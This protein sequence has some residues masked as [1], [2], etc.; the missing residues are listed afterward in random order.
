MPPNQQGFVNQ[1]LK[2]TNGEGGGMEQY[3]GFTKQ[4]FR[5]VRQL[6]D[7]EWRVYCCLREKADF[8][9]GRLEH[10]TALKMTAASIAR[11]ISLP[12]QSGVP[13]LD[14]SRFDVLRSLDRLE[15][16]GFI[17]EREREGR[18]LRLRMP[19]VLTNTAK[20]E[21]SQTRV[22]PKNA[23]GATNSS[24]GVQQTKIA[25]TQAGQGFQEFSAARVQ[26]E[27]ASG[28]NEKSAR[29]QQTENA[30]I[31]ETVAAQGIADGKIVPFSTVFSTKNLQYSP[32]PPKN[33]GEENPLPSASE[34]PNPN[35]PS[36]DG[37]QEEAEKTETEIRRL[38]TVV[39]NSA[40]ECGGVIRCLNSAKS[41]EVLESWIPAGFKDWWI[42]DAVKLVIETPSEQPFVNAIDAVM[43]KWSAN[44]QKKSL[45][46]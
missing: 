15:Y 25:E 39:A 35:S 12:G 11:D 21:P 14:F 5:A 34:K 37:S 23:Q 26:Q 10:P 29:V 24:L 30:E 41:T 1:I 17:D 19:M 22:Q 38:R 2:P 27:T 28:C 18:F 4:E 9:T 31:P 16:L 8:K 42:Q 33:G 46:L 36:A 32:L 20:S 43:R 6:R 13:A 7:C 44:S 40:K 45:C 3:F